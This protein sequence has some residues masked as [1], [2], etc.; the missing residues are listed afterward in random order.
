MQN[1]KLY[2]TERQIIDFLTVIEDCLNDTTF[3]QDR[4]LFQQDIAT[5]AA[6][7]TSLHRGEPVE[8]VISRILDPQTDK[9]FG[10]YWR[11]GEW[12]VKEME[13]LKK[14]QMSLSPLL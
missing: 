4:S 3:A 12:G 6:W 1:E 11:Q 7:L 13:A 10:D 8:D 9:Y 2:T 5:A 14:L